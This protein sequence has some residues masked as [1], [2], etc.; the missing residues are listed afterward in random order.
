VILRRN[1]VHYRHSAA[2]KNIRC[3]TSRRCPQ[4]IRPL[5]V[6]HT[7]SKLVHQAATMCR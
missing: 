5:A 6:K 4:E 3:R 1:T 2:V 7:L